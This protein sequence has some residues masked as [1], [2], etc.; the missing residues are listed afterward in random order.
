MISLKLQIKVGGQQMIRQILPLSICPMDHGCKDRINPPS[1]KSTFLW[2][3]NHNW[4]F[5]EWAMADDTD[6]RSYLS[7]CAKVAQSELGGPEVPEIYPSL[8]AII[9]LTFQTWT[10]TG[11][12]AHVTWVMPKSTQLWCPY[13]SSWNDEVLFCLFQAV[14]IEVV[15]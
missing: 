15:K 4:W 11:I 7:V 2:W 13:R 3:V 10:R 14:D 1:N 6:F 9:F 5:T 12:L 8:R